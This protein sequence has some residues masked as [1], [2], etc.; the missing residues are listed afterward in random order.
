MRTAGLPSPDP[1]TMPQETKV[2]AS[3]SWSF[4]PLRSQVFLTTLFIGGLA[5]VFAGLGFLWFEKFAASV[6]PL[7]LGTGMIGTSIWCWVRSQPDVDMQGSPPVSVRVHPDAST[8]IAFDPRMLTSGDGRARALMRIIGNA[9]NRA[10]LPDPDG[11]VDQRGIPIPNSADEARARVRV[12]NERAQEMDGK[13]LEGLGRSADA[14]GQSIGPTAV[15]ADP[16]V[17]AHNIAKPSTEE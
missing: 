8:E 1:T 13:V 2:E 4:K 6:I 15:P 14:Q 17:I 5:I 16:A 7:V 9:L 3:A 11:L 10:P 12:V